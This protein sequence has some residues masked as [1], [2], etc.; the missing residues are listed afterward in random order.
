MLN[1]GTHLENLGAKIINIIVRNCCIITS[2]I[3]RVG[4]GGSTFE[5]DYS[6]FSFLNKHWIVIAHNK[7]EIGFEIHKRLS[8]F[9]I[10]K[11]EN[12]RL[13]HPKSLRRFIWQI[14][15]ILF[16]SILSKHIT[17]HIWINLIS[18]ISISF[19]WRK[20]GWKD[21]WVPTQF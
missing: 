13:R 1:Q 5:I 16:N 7:T 6:I 19:E 21:F 20:K 2:I 14:G 17:K 11:D 4:R 15:M 12:S 8:A 18:W 3:K 9:L 10:I